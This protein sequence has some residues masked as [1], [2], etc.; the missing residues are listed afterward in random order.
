MHLKQNIYSDETQ[1][2][3]SK[4]RRHNLTS[5]IPSRS[6]GAGVRLFLLR[7]MLEDGHIREVYILYLCSFYMIIF[8][9]I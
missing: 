8:H 1:K 5:T 9:F 2:H 6:C 7:I 4:G 3:I